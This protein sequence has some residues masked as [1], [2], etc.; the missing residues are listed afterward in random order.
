LEHCHLPRLAIER[1]RWRALTTGAI[2]K[3]M[4]ITSLVD[5][6]IIEDVVVMAPETPA[7]NITLDLD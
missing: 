4:P 1:R 5:R 7:A 6:A 2:V 3:E